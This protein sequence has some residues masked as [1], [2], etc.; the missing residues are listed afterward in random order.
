MKGRDEIITSRTERNIQFKL[1]S[2]S[3][4]SLV[5]LREKNVHQI[6]SICDLRKERKEL[7]LSKFFCMENLHASDISYE[8]E[9][10]RIRI[11]ITKRKREICLVSSYVLI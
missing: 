3:F 8:I 6:S 7:I 10:S 1:S 4:K 2:K 9:I 11:M 5:K